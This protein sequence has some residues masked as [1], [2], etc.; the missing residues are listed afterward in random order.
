MPRPSKK[1]QAI[2]GTSTEPPSP[3][4]FTPLPSSL[5]PLIPTLSPS[6]I[7]VLHVD[8][9][10][11][12]LKAKIFAIPVLMHLVILL[13]LLWRAYIILPDYLGILLSI[14]GVQ[15]AFLV[16]LSQTSK[17]DLAW[18]AAYRAK[19]FMIDW[20]LYM[21]LLPWPMNFLRRTPAGPAVWRWKLGF[22]EKELVVRESIGW[23]EG[24][25]QL[26]STTEKETLVKEKATKALDPWY[27]VN[28][29]SYVMINADWD[30]NY[31]AMITARALI[32]K[33]V[34]D[35][36]EPQECVLAAWGEDQ[37]W[38]IWRPNLSGTTGKKDNR[39]VILSF[40]KK[41][42]DI[43]KEKL[44]YRWME[45]VQYES[46]QTGGFTEERQMNTMKQVQGMFE[47]EGVNFGEF[48]R[49]VGGMEGAVA[50][51]SWD[52]VD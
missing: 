40:Q 43:G 16:D 6:R 51:E 22:Q 32:D 2:K 15:N 10:H 31:E 36:D 46:T 23:S 19:S 1:S 42:T 37:G 8:T 21:F 44:F 24:L 30:L 4:L 7:Y 9:H 39:K 27:L 52:V 11:T 45:L 50:D 18:L 20:A 13:A 34:L 49:S 48:W 3:P 38:S 41:L 47:K 5:K 14:G 17:R 26:G 35:L 25:G 12:S 28:T 33:K 29:T